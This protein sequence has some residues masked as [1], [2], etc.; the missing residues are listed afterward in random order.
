[1]GLW[2]D[3]Y[4]I[5]NHTAPIVCKLT[6]VHPPIGNGGS[7]GWNDDAY[8]RFQVWAIVQNTSQ[9]LKVYVGFETNK[10]TKPLVYQFS[11]R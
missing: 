8:F 11:L 5:L 7:Y 1:M 10:N 3:K 9:N 6:T 2:Q 4:T